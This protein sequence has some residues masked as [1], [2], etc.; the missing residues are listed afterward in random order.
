MEIGDGSYPQG[1]FVYM[2]LSPIQSARKKQSF[3]RTRKK[4]VQKTSPCL[5]K[6]RYIH[7]PTDPIKLN[8]TTLKWDPILSSGSHGLEI[9]VI[10][11]AKPAEA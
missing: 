7:H 3:V 8:L 11:G 9:F 10:A 2:M 1:N 5:S 6:R 4:K